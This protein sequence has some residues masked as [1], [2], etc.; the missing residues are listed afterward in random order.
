MSNV[1]QRH[2]FAGKKK[3]YRPTKKTEELNFHISFVFL[4]FPSQYG[5]ILRKISRK[6]DK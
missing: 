4:I 6:H 2:Y 3:S 5:D 1:N